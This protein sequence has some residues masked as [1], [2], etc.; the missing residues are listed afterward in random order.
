MK[1]F[2]LLL[3]C[4]VGFMA[5][6]AAQVSITFS[7]QGYSNAQE[8]TSVVLDDNITLVFDK[9]TNSNTCKYYKT[10]TAI[11]VYGGGTMTV[12]GVSG[13]TISKV[14]MT[15]QSSNPVN[16]ASTVSAGTLTRTTTAATIDGVNAESVVFTQGGT[17]GHVRI[18]TVTVEY[19][20]G[21][22][23]QANTPVIT[24]NGGEVTADTE[25]SIECA[26]EGASIYYTIDGTEP[27]TSSTLYTAPFRLSAATIVK[28]IA[29]AEGL[30]ASAVAEA[31][32]TF[33]VAN[34]GEFIS[35]ANPNATTIAGP[36][37]VVAQAGSYLFL[38]DATGRIVAFGSLNNAYNNGDQLSNIK[39]SYTLY[40]GLPEMNVDATSFGAATAGAAVAPEEITIEEVA[41]DNLLAYVKL[42][43]VTI[44]ESSSKSFTISDET[45]S[46]TMY[47]SAG[48]TVPTGENMTVIGF[49]S[50]YNTTVQILPVE[51]T[52]ASGLEVVEAPVISPDG[53]A[54]ATNQ[55]IT[56]TCA[57]EGASIY[58]TIDGTEP[59]TSS[60]LYE[61]AFTLAEECT[62]KAIA[63][64]EGMANSAV[65]EA[66]F[67]F[68]SEDLKVAT[69]DFTNPGSLNPAQD[70][71]A[72]GVQEFT[73]V[74]GTTLTYGA[75]SLV[76][77]KGSA[78][79][80]CRLWG[81][82][83]YIDLRTYK[84]STIT[85]S[86][87]NANITS[88]EFTGGKASATQMTADS[89]ELTG[90]VWTASDSVSSVVFT[91]IA[92]TNIETITV[93]YAAATDGVE[94]IIVD[95]NAPAVYYNLQGV[96]VDE[97]QGG[98]FIKVQGEKASKVYVK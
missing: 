85:I 38:Q 58:Y 21:A 25:I 82:S 16:T 62:V 31:E 83:S 19:S 40:N 66:A 12:Q 28:A 93:N 22:A 75:I 77:D 6:N 5:A 45:G 20:V 37:T 4:L 76:C 33:P 52:S 41:I 51:I 26:T 32:F 57:T 50:C 48:I 54:I 24:P 27:S 35:A 49:I 91:A 1:K 78:G 34:I 71:P 39:G 70:A 63:V 69:F 55:E 29:I 80:D 18:Q 98:I 94:G 42:T 44:P 14:S 95:S 73:V 60:T 92:T 72:L 46:M 59:S 64:A 7:E 47:N 3:A 11:R 9:G 23:T 30:E 10:G 8:I 43:G 97:P 67:T 36:V 74:N 17:S 84:G 61:G 15:T 89:G 68:L 79:T 87:T 90:K 88:V 53:G 96:K 81:G 65:V 2:L 56:I 86:A 13:V